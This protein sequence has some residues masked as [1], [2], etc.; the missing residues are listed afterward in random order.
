MSDIK[1][2]LQE[3]KGIKNFT[4]VLL[5]VISVSSVYLLIFNHY[6]FLFSTVAALYGLSTIKFKAAKIN[7]S[8]IDIE[9]R[10]IIH[11]LDQ[12]ESIE[13]KDIESITY[14]KGF[15]DKKFLLIDILFADSMFRGNTRPTYILLRMKDKEEKYIMKMGKQSIPTAYYILRDSGL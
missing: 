14:R 5:L 3:P 12:Y 8:S 7:E 1:F 9:Y 13:F 15:V 2:T 6:L 11:Q 10:G 4:F